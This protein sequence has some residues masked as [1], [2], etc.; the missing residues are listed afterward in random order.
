LQGELD[1][2]SAA[3]GAAANLLWREGEFVGDPL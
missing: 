1:G 2:A 3:A